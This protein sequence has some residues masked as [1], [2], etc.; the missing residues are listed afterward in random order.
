MNT[1]RC[2]TSLATIAIATLLL[3]IT[4]PA[5]ATVTAEWL[6]DEEIDEGDDVYRYPETSGFTDGKG[7]DPLDFLMVL[8]EGELEGEMKRG[9]VS[10]DVPP[11]SPVGTGSFFYSGADEMLSNDSTLGQLSASKTENATTGQRTLEFWYKSHDAYSVNSLLHHND[12]ETFGSTDG[13]GWSIHQTHAHAPFPGIDEGIFGLRQWHTPDGGGASGPAVGKDTNSFYPPSSDPFNPQPEDGKTIPIEDG[14]VWFTTA[15]PR[16]ATVE[17]NNPGLEEGDWHH[18]AFT[19]DLGLDEAKLFVDGVEV[20]TNWA[21]GDRF[22]Q[23]AWSPLLDAPLSIGRSSDGSQGGSGIG[24]KID[25]L[26]FSDEILVPGDGCGGPGVMA[27]NTS[28][29]P[30]AVCGQ[31]VDHGTGS[32]PL[33]GDANNDDL[34]TGADLISVQQNFGTVYPSDPSCDGMGLGDANSDCLV[35][36][37]DLITVQQN[38]GNVAG[39]QDA[40][41]P[42]PATGGLLA[43]SILML[44]RRRANG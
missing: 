31:V 2:I 32:G 26:R 40:A 15:L 3:A 35:T 28:F 9:E 11:F 19:T 38:F 27:W 41:L 25:D 13:N 30:G 23:Y 12:W 29:S 17:D 8:S 20:T 33:L 34:V 4:M 36:G 18:F 6:F 16:A 43:A 24:F 10:N 7:E 21:S 5:S 42:E 44:R 22:S 39:G 1:S 14:G 37:A